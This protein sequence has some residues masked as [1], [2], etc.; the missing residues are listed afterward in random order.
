MPTLVL[1]VVF[2]DE[3]R[4]LASILNGVVLSNDIGCAVNPQAVPAPN[5]SDGVLVEFNNGTSNTD[6]RTF[7]ST[8][9]GVALGVNLRSVVGGQ[10]GALSGGD[11][12]VVH[13]E[14]VLNDARGFQG[15][16][17]NSVTL[18]VYL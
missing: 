3:H 8:A 6:A 7:C 15:V 13:F 14:R 1:V 12:V 11:D 17:V 10:T 5:G 16:R 2:A 4:F 9:D 18:D